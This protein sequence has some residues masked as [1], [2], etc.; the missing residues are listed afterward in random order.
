MSDELFE[1]EVHAQKENL[2]KPSRFRQAHKKVC[3]ENERK[4]SACVKILLME[5]STL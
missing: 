4:N 5:G 3:D 1:K 2:K